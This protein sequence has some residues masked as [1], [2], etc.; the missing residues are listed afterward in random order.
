MAIDSRHQESVTSVLRNGEYAE[1]QRQELLDA[2]LQSGALEKARV[3]AD[4]F[5]QSA[6]KSLDILPN[7][8]YS[9][10]LRT[11]PMYIL[12]RDR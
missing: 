7:S 2:I 8:P 9:D 12:D 3:M 4:D 5:A 11:L 10:S 1:G 6:Q